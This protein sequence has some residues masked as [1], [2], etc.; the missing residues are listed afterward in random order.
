VAEKKVA[1]SVVALS[2]A[3][4]LAIY[5]AGYARTR[6]AAD[7]FAQQATHRRP[8]IPAPVDER[9]A[10]T[11]DGAVAAPVAA[12]PIPL[13]AAKPSPAAPAETVAARSAASASPAATPVTASTAN[14]EKV[15]APPIAGLPTINVAGASAMP[16]S[17]MA[18]S[19]V[20]AS[21]PSPVSTPAAPAEPAKPLY[22]D[23][24]YYGWGTSRHGDIQAAVVIE[25]G[26]I[27][28]ARV[29]Q[30]L[31]RYSCNWITPIPPRILI[32]QA[33]TY[34]YVSGATESSDAFQDAVSEALSQAK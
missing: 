11:T 8:H 23:G 6:E 24:T 20:T 1:N 2:S 5:G 31:T 26:K 33:T 13:Q 15:T 4:V 3:A 30:C 16:A 22:K 7:R 21:A 17:S 9:P 19:P 29:E 28:V 32:K 25:E 34:D 27:A 10:G 12:A 14:S 18:P